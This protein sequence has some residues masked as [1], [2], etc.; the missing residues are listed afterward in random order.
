VVTVDV[1]GEDDDI[2]CRGSSDQLEFWK[3]TSEE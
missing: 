2:S 3:R 1:G